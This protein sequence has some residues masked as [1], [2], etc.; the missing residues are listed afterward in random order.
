MPYVQKFYDYFLMVFICFKYHRKIPSLY[1]E[2]CNILTVVTVMIQYKCKGVC[3]NEF[4]FYMCIV[5]YQLL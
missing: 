2:S 3:L 1:E 5:L 4:L